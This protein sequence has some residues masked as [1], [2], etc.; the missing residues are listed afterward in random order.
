MLGNNIS[1]LQLTQFCCKICFVAIYA[2]LCGEILNQKLC[3]WRK[4]DKYKVWACVRVP[5][6]APP[7]Q[8]EHIMQFSKCRMH[9]VPNQTHT[10]RCTLYIILNI[11][12]PSNAALY[13]A[14]PQLSKAF[15]CTKFIADLAIQSIHIGVH[16]ASSQPT[17]ETQLADLRCV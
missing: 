2:L 1:L 16:I 15:L 5:H 17:L 6:Q 12:S 9:T 13:R 14:C 7:V 3:W 8:F 4:K 11:S 10:V